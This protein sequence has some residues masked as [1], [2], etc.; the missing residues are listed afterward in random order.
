MRFLALLSFFASAITTICSSANS[1]LK[2]T[3]LVFSPDPP[4]ANQNTTLYLK[5]NNPGNVK[6][7]N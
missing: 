4:I 2:I 6:C 3:D 5:F 1:L 7:H